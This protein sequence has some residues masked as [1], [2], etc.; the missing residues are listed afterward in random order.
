MMQNRDSIFRHPMMCVAVLG[1]EDNYAMFKEIFQEYRIV[2]QVVTRR[3]AEK[4]N[5][6]KATNIL[7][8]IN[9]KIGGDL[10]NMKFP[11]TM[12]RM[13]TMLIGIDV[14]HAGP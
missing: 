10:Y 6:S 3:N 11:D 2:S 4:F 14:C 13:R 7:K 9:S 1:N 5:L 12:S 8:Q